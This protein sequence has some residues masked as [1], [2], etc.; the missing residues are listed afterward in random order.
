MVGF[1]TGY[2]T[3]TE[4]VLV[5]LEEALLPISA[6]EYPYLWLQND[7]FLC[8]ILRLNKNYTLL[9]RRVA[10]NLDMKCVEMW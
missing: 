1:V 8:F 6:L 9:F 5:L 4:D 3:N 7:A 10:L 2:G